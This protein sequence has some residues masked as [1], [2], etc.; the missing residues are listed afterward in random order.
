MKTVFQEVI[1]LRCLVLHTVSYIQVHIRGPFRS[2]Q[3]VEM[4]N[5]CAGSKDVEYVAPHEVLLF[6]LFTLVISV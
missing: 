3:Y 4:G 6:R 1:I 2:I 5:I